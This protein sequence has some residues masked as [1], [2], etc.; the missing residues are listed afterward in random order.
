LQLAVGGL[1]PVVAFDGGVVVAGGAAW[2]ANPDC[3]L[4]SPGTYA[5]RPPVDY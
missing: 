4:F 5:Y 2:R 1:Q 3:C